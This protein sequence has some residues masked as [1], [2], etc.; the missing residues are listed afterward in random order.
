MANVPNTST[1]TFQD[2]TTSVYND[3]AAGRNLSGSFGAATG[4]FDPSYVGSKNQLYNFRN[5]VNYTIPTLWGG[6]YNVATSTGNFG[7]SRTDKSLTFTWGDYSLVECSSSGTYILCVP[8]LANYIY[9]STNGGSSFTTLNGMDYGSVGTAMSS[10]GQY[11]YYAEYDNVNYVAHI[12]RQNNYLGG[13]FSEVGTIYDVAFPP[14]GYSPLIQN[15][16][17]SSNGQYVTLKDWTY[18]YV[19]SD[20][21]ANWSTIDG[22]SI[23]YR[24]AMNGTGQ[25]QYG[26]GGSQYYLK[27]SSNYG[28]TWGT[29]TPPSSMASTNAVF[30]AVSRDSAYMIAGILGSTRACVSSNRGSSWGSEISFTNIPGGN[31]IAGMAVSPTGKTM[32]VTMCNGTSNIS[33]QVSKDYGTTWNRESAYTGFNTQWKFLG[34]I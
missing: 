8:Y 28:A 17:C 29:W 2:V 24:L 33:N 12:W 18:Y 21:G 25:Y 11:S 9:R 13:Y 34:D 19:S 16:A 4:T 6:G 27:Y 22:T 20:Y 14:W 26:L 1:F 15:M 3:T 31:T 23:G 10:N 7:A 30:V 5:Y 32:I